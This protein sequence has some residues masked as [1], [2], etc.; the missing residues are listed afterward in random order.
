MQPDFQAVTAD[1]LPGFLT[2]MQQLYADTGMPWSPRT[3]ENSLEELLRTPEKGGAWL[4]RMDAIPVGY[5]VLT[6]AF[7]LEFGGVFALLD[8]LYVV[9]ESRGQGIGSAALRFIE[10]Q[11]RE[12]GAA[13]L[14]LETGTENTSALRFYE[15]H[16]LGREERYL[17]TK[18][19]S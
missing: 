16:G 2:L 5:F 9:P 11:C 3:A 8:E 14:R 7:S 4:I 19:L 10:E 1:Q 17:M 13:T 12:L 15:R 18:R 6:L